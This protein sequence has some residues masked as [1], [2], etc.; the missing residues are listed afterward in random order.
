M[1]DVLNIGRALIHARTTVGTRPQHIIIDNAGHGQYIHALVRVVVI[2]CALAQ[3][4]HELFGAQRFLGIPG[5]AKL[6]AAAALGTRGGIQQHLPAAWCDVLFQVRG[7]QGLQCLLT[8]GIALEE[9]I[10]KAGEA[11][12]HDAPLEIAGDKDDK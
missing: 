5:R 1:I 8:G 11:V 6:L 3:V 12:P 7:G 4:H 10:E 9:D 2:Q